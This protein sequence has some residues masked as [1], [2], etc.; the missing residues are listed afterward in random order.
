M[1]NNRKANWRKEITIAVE[2]KL[3]NVRS[4]K[5]EEGPL[6]VVDLTNQRQ[7]M[8]EDGKFHN[9]VFN[10]QPLCLPRY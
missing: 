3:L 1:P 8:Q 2:Q 5:I 6:L 10:G 7:F 9:Y 4:A